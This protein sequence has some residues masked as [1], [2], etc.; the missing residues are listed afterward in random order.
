MTT[1]TTTWCNGVHG[2]DNARPATSQEQQKGRYETAVPSKAA[3]AWQEVDEVTTRISMPWTT[4]F[5]DEEERRHHR[6]R[7]CLQSS[8]H[9]ASA[10]VVD[11]TVIVVV[12]VAVIVVEYDAVG[13]VAINSFH[14]AVATR[15]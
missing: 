3:T 5:L 14:T 6:R 8:L 1:K 9:D 13:A 7:Y 2:D 4:A 10:V 15:R 11:V 12:I